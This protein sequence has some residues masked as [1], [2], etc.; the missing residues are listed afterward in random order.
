LLSSF[1]QRTSQDNIG[2]RPICIR[3]IVPSVAAGKPTQNGAPDRM[4]E[5]LATL[6]ARCLVMIFSANQQIDQ[7]SLPKDYEQL[8]IKGRRSGKSAQY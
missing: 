4:M 3:D 8:V 7:I 5:Y 2:Q 6:Q 1:G